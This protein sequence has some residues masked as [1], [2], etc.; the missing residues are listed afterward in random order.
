MPMHDWTR[1]DA[2]TYHNFHQD[3]TIEICR[4]LNRGI[5][6]SGY[7]SM[8]DLKVGGTEP[9][10]ATLKLRDQLLHI[11]VVRLALI[12]WMSHVESRIVVLQ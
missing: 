3:W 12:G 2:G 9:D 11:T 8:V 6:P 1:V 10:V 7:M 4:T 5:L